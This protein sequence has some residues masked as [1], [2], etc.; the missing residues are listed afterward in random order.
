MLLEPLAQVRAV[1]S[2]A[3]CAHHE[4]G[5]RLRR[6]AQRGVDVGGHQVGLNAEGAVET[7]RLAVRVAEYSRLPGLRRG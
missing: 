2:G 5:G 1:R 3:S 7:S 6:L 4:H